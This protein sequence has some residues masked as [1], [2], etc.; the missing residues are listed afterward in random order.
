MFLGAEKNLDE[1]LD[2]LPR[3]L[4]MGVG[5]TLGKTLTALNSSFLTYKLWVLD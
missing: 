4:L 3:L 2:G 1:T 5:G